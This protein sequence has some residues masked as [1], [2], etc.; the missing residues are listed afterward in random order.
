M[1]KK[2]EPYT[3]VS[4]NGGGEDT[5]VP[6]ETI[7]Q[8]IPWRDT[9]TI[10]SPHL[11]KAAGEETPARRQVDYPALLDVAAQLLRAIGEDPARPGLVDTP[12]RF[13][14]MWRDFIEY[15]PGRTET[16]FQEAR[17]DQIVLV[18]G[19]RVW[20]YCEHHLLPFWC[21]IDIA[22]LP[23]GCVLGLSKFARVAHAVAH[24][25]QLQERLVEQIADE[26]SRLTQSPDVAVL[27][28][29]EHLCMSARGI[30]TDARMSSSIVRGFFRD[31]AQA[32]AELLQMVG[33]ARAGRL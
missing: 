12:R 5:I 30:R 32:R 6:G 8:A 1:D 7:H 25:L 14:D 33:L 11:I 28:I 29:G 18:S 16:I 21:D 13:A 19:M 31:N 17:A 22:Y 20:S 27:A 3:I 26:I 24:S 15:D 23:H 9:R 4:G 2:H 10:V